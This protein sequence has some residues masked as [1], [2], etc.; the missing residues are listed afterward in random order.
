MLFAFGNVQERHLM[1]AKPHILEGAPNAL[2]ERSV[3][4]QVQQVAIRLLPHSVLSCQLNK[5]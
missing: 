3:G 2:A 4:L 5:C 1:C